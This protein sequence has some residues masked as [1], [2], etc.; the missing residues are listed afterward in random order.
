MRKLREEYEV[1]SRDYDQVRQG[2]YSV[3]ANYQTVLQALSEVTISKD[4]LEAKVE[5]SQSVIKELERR[6]EAAKKEIK[7]LHARL[8]SK[9]EPIPT[10]VNSAQTEEGKGS[11][12]KAR[13]EATER[14][15]SNQV[16]GQLHSIKKELE[17]L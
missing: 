6:R 13:T 12:Y 5:E 14:G 15:C 7:M 11:N 1:L 16:T 8:A 3:E 10:G 2:K 9:R 17:K 4:E